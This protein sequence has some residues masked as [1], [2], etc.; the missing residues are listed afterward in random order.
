MNKHLLIYLI[1]IPQILWATEKNGQVII[2]Y[3]YANSFE[4]VIERND[5][6]MTIDWAQESATMVPCSNSTTP[7]PDCSHGRDSG[8]TGANNGDGHVGFSFTK[9]DLNGQ[10]LPDNTALGAQNWHCNRDNVTGLVWERKIPFSTGIHGLGVAGD[11]T[12]QYRWGGITHVGSNYSSDSNPY[13]DDWDVII[14]AS[15]TENLC[16]FSDWR[17]PTRAELAD[18]IDYS[19]PWTW[20]SNHGTIYIDPTIQFLDYRENTPIFWTA[21]PSAQLENYAISIN[22]K[23]SEINHI[24]RNAKYNVILVRG[25]KQ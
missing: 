11:D 16:G 8:A 3:I 2:D 20:N 25:E 4:Y 21:T 6:G 13:Y 5:T 12:N 14:N 18:I 1:C 19:G 10:A 23:T 9:L 17:M 24:N 7:Q 15:N 22:F